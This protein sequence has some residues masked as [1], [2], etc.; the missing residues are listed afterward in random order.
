MKKQR[1]G[2]LT[3]G[4]DCPGLNS[5]IRAIVK[6]AREKYNMET[7]GFMHG[8]QGILTGD[9]RELT[10]SRV[11][12]ILTKGG[13]ILGTSREKP[14][15]DE[16]I[17]DRHP[18]KI[19]K[20]Y[21]ELGLDCLLTLGGNGT[22]KTAYKLAVQQ[23]MNVIGLP[24][25]IDNDIFGTEICFGFYSAV[26]IA[27]EAIDRIHTT[28]HS[29]NRIM[30]VEI[31]GHHTGWLALYSGVAG[32]GDVI[33]IPEI[34][35]DVE[36][37]AKS[38]EK[39]SQAGKEFSIVAVA[40]GALSLEEAA[41]SKKAFKEKRAGEPSIGYRIAKE[42]E[43]ATGLESRLTVLGY[44]QRG[45]SPNPQDRILSTKMGAFAVD[46][47]KNKEYGR[48]VA[49]RNGKIVSLDLEE[50]AG[51]IRYV[52]KDDPILRAGRNIGTCFGD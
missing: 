25:T 36:V 34:P 15:S 33:L 19:K 11:S 51:K 45:G 32:G 21:D 48:M 16:G 43:A 38:I 41:L 47:V 24:K 40:E 30:V 18:E 35:Y 23:D 5:T 12:G 13:T 29:H 27:T 1:I 4:G 2:I 9:Y 20:V 26:D 8:F 31:M 37:I 14:F 39:R 50:V 42:I 10:S 3:A 49:M 44:V 28:A 52:P 7:V 46:M 17:K 6:T 22:Q